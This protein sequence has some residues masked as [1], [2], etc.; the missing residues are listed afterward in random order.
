MTDDTAQTPAAADPRDPLDPPRAAALLGYAGAIPFITAAVIVFFLYP[1]D[2]A[3][4]VLAIQIGYGAVILSFLGGIRW[5][6]A[7]LF[8]EDEALLKK[9][10]LSALPALTGWVALI[11][12]P[13]WGLPLLIVAFWA[14]ASSDVAATKRNKAP[15]WYGGYRVR[16]TILVVA[17]LLVSAVGMLLRS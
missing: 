11:V 16:I 9:L 15:R 14:Q 7:M 13:A 17:A 8:P 4:T 10:A 2:E 5:A 1:R 6:L 12:P 3:Q